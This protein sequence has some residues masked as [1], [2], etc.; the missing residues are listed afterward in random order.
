MANNI[1]VS[2]KGS[3]K[4]G[5]ELVHAKGQQDLTL[6]DMKTFHYLL[7]RSYNKL[8]EQTLFTIPVADLLTYLNHSSVSKVQQTLQKLGDVTIC[9]EYTNPE[10]GDEHEAKA[11][12]LSYDVSKAENGVLTYAFDP[13][14]LQ[15]LY[16]PKVYA[17]L[18]LNFI[19]SFKTT[20]GS[21]LYEVMSFFQHRYSRVWPVPIDEFRERMGVAV[22]Q[23]TRF[24]NLKLNV[25]EKAVQEVNAIAEFWVEVEYVRGGRGNKVI[26]LRFSIVP[27]P[28]EISIAGEALTK[29]KPGRKK[30]IADRD[31]NTVDM[32]DGK[33]DS[34]RDDDLPLSN[35]ALDNGKELLM[36]NGKAPETIVGLEDE[37]REAVKGNFVSDPDLNFLRWLNL[38]LQKENLDVLDDVDEDLFG[39]ILEDFE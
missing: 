23:Y 28:S 17:K 37:W 10:T 39:S 34:E 3:F 5:Y 38:K 35:E 1:I 4:K 21:K 16:E 14:L 7:Q 2:G 13:I 12:F 15:F 33:T 6:S 19:R 30:K 18:N 9:I 36:E 26:E 27:R 32:L 8:Q 11:H 25:I 31:P 24:D 20:Y 29:G 22:D